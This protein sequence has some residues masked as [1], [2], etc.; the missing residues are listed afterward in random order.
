[1]C[2]R[3]YLDGLRQTSGPSMTLGRC[4][5]RERYFPRDGYTTM[6]LA[7][8][9]IFTF[10]NVCSYTAAPVAGVPLPG[11]NPTPSGPTLMSQPAICTGVASRPR[12]GLSI[13]LGFTPA[14]AQAP[15]TSASATQ[16]RS[17]VDMLHLAVRR[18]AP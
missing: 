7:G 16:A 14:L 15:T 8:L 11:G 9:G 2:E 17:R 3:E 13:A 6:K 18:H 4:R 10:G 1:M 5:A 12:F